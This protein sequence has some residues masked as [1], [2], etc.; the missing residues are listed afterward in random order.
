MESPRMPDVQNVAAWRGSTTDLTLGT[1][2]AETAKARP[3]ARL[4]MVDEAGEREVSLGWVYGQARRLAGGLQALGLNPGDVIGVQMPNRLET[5]LAHAAAAV[6]GLVVLPIIHIYG[7]NELK[8]I[9][10]QS[11]AKAIV[12]PDVLKGADYVARVRAAGPSV[13]HIVVGEAA[14]PAIAWA[15]LLDAGSL[16]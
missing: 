10:E 14:A 12:T 9:L 11:G 6:A 7:E 1:A 3:D 8:F 16:A 5:L 2:F 13:K 4:I 15:S